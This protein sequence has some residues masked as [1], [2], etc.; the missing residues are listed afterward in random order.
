MKDKENTKIKVW[1]AKNTDGML[2]LF[3]SEP[4]RI[5]DSWIGDFYVNSVVYN[6]IKSMIDGTSFSNADDAQYI[7]YFV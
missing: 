3:T 2:L 1:F 4:T 7:E 5:S 6:D